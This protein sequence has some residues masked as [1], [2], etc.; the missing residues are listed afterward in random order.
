M[1]S[2]PLRATRPDPLTPE[3]RRRNMSAIRGK[4]T[5][6]EMLLRRAL[7]AAGFRYRL[8]V[9]TLPGAPDLVFPS[10][11]AV[12]FVNGCF[13]HGHDCP[14]FKLPASNRSFWQE[15]IRRN[16]DVDQRALYNL[17]ADGWRTLT[18]WE[19]AIR[20]GGRLHLPSLVE[21]I[22]DWLGNGSEGREIR[23]KG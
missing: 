7:H 18:V 16:R 4:N 6:P 15:K 17:K 13:W 12:I 20:G 11:R 14:L 8:H 2:P 9:K 19:C 22:G 3:Q 23:G 1:E 10:R 5:K 21:L